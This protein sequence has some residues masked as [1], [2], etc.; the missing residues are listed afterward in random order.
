MVPQPQTGTTIPSQ[1]EENINS[2]IGGSGHGAPNASHHRHLFENSSFQPQYIR[3]KEVP[4]NFKA[5]PSTVA[6]LLRTENT[7]PTVES[8][9]SH[10]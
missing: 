6:S 2:H 7:R 5:Q 8:L 10:Q 1:T 4:R 3:P 9:F